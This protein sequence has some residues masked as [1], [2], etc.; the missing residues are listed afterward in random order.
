MASAG[1]VPNEARAAFVGTLGLCVRLGKVLPMHMVMLAATA[2]T[3]EATGSNPLMFMLIIALATLLGG[4]IYAMRAR[5]EGRGGG[6]R[7]ASASAQPQRPARKK[8]PHKKR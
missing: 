7:S 4:G 8:R 5:R 6:G 2:A 1:Y 3:Q